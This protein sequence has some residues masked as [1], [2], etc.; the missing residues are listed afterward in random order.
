MKK[1]KIFI[2]SSHLVFIIFL[3]R[4][5]GTSLKEVQKHDIGKC[6]QNVRGVMVVVNF[7]FFKLRHFVSEWDEHGAS[8]FL[9]RDLC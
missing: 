3:V 9:V 6:Q 5:K 8:W 1:V 2:K 7:F 4:E